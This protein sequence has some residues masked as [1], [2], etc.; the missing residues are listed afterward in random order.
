MFEDKLSLETLQ[1]WQTERNNPFTPPPSK[2]VHVM[3]HI[4]T[5][6]EVDPDWDPALFLR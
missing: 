4:H 3:K 1:A 2:I 5:I 6:P